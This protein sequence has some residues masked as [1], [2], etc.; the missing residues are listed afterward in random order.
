[1]SQRPTGVTVIALYFL[2]I[3]AFSLVWSLFAFGAGGISSAFSGL[4]GA[5]NINA[6]ASAG[7]WSGFLGIIAA[8][9]QIAVGAGLFSMKPWAWYV[10][11][12]AIALAVI[13]GITGMM[14][15]TTFMLL[16][17]FLWLLIPIAFLIY[18]IRERGRFGVGF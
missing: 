3:G 14:G 4:L 7:M 13:Q 6:L 5:D 15:G 17:G 1:M 18:L 11:V 8:I 10:A 9:V 12:V 2:I 16:C